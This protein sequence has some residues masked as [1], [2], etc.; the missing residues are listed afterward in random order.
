M[1]MIS[2]EEKIIVWFLPLTFNLLMF[3]HLHFSLV[4][5]S[6]GYYLNFSLVLISFLLFLSA[7]FTV[8]L[9]HGLDIRWYN[10][11][12]S[13]DNIGYFF[14]NI[15]GLQAITPICLWD[16]QIFYLFLQLIYLHFSLVLPIFSKDNFSFLLIFHWL[17]N[18]YS[19]A[20]TAFC[21]NLILLWARKVFLVENRSL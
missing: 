4:E 21:M 20:L 9:V 14:D 7:F 16:L 12:A 18:I 1:G 8:F 6:M 5:K 10:H 11:L 3:H 19:R 2:T 15:A 13:T 17:L